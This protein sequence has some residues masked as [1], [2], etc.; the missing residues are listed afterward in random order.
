MDPKRLQSVEEVITCCLL[1]LQRAGKHSKVLQ[2]EGNNHE[3]V[4]EIAG[5][6]NCNHMSVRSQ[7]TSRDTD[8]FYLHFRVDP[9]TVSLALIGRFEK[10]PLCR[11]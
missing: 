10:Q 3:A 2:Q 5:N 8:I 6:S 4:R 9:S 11:N 1:Q 7:Y